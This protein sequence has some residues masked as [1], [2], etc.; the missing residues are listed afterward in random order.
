MTIIFKSIQPLSIS[1]TGFCNLTKS[2]KTVTV[3]CWQKIGKEGAECFWDAVRWRMKVRYSARL[4]RRGL[5]SLLVSRT[6]AGRKLAEVRMVNLVHI[7]L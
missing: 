4:I 6:E 7:Q 1:L 3:G 5:E 2:Y